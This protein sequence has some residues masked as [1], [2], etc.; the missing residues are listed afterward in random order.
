MSLR[1]YLLYLLFLKT[2]V[3]AGGLGFESLDGQIVHCRQ[4]LA[5]AAMFLC[6]CRPGA[7]PRKYLMTSCEYNDDV[8]LTFKS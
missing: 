5:T 1:D 7:K 3:A 2:F 6:S 8:I 4:R